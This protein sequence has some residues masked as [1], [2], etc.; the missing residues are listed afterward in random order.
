MTWYGRKYLLIFSLETPNDSNT[1]SVDLDGA[2]RRSR[3][4]WRPAAKKNPEEKVPV[5][6]FLSWSTRRDVGLIH[7]VL[8]QESP[9]AVF[10]IG[11]Q[12]FFD[13][14]EAQMGILVERDGTEGEVV[15]AVGDDQSSRDLWLLRREVGSV[16]T[17]GGDVQS[18]TS[19]GSCLTSGRA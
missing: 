4:N 1:P 7:L 18:L 10:I 17:S 8:V 11:L 15:E 19:G 3:K 6:N 9:L 14:H 5:H 16:Q 13:F 2:S 12:V